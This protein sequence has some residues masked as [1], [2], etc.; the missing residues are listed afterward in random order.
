MTRWQSCKA[1]LSIN[2]ISEDVYT[3]VEHRDLEDSEKSDS[4]DSEYI[5]DNEWSSKNEPEDAEDKEGSQMDEKPSTV[6]KKKKKKA[7]TGKPS[8]D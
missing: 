8:G 1:R 2:E 3:A 4:S 6:Q 7:Q 5:S